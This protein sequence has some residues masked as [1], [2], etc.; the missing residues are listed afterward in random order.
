MKNDVGYLIKRINDKLAA[1]TDG[2]KAIQ[3]DGVPM[4]GISVSEQPGRAGNPERNRNLFGRCS[5]DVVGLVSCHG[6]KR[7]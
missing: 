1:R 2:I 6:A 7:L 3:F 4:P 5:S